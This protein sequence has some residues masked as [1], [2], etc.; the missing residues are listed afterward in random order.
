MKYSI[1][2]PVRDEENSIWKLIYSILEQ[3]YIPNE[4][5]V[6]VNGSK[7]NT[8]EI[9]KDLADKEEKIRLI[10]SDPWKANAINKIIKTTSNKIMIF[11]DW[12]IKIWN[13]N[14]FEVILNELENLNL[15][16]LWTS[17]IQQPSNRKTPY[18][19][20]VPSWQ[21][22]WINLEKLKINELPNN[23]INDDLYLA[24][25]SYPNVWVSSNAFFYSEKPSIKDIFT[26]Q[27]RIIK[28]IKQIID[29]W[30]KDKLLEYINWKYSKTK[31]NFILWV[32]KYIK[33]KENDYIWTQTKSTKT[34]SLYDS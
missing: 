29:M 19:L 27:F 8:Y 31:I 25:L 30:M 9:V 5:I 4:I 18:K 3:S 14:C 1:W 10:E 28:W 33:L 26:T 24:L 32:I 16:M 21:L 11:C 2:I 13:H 34:W 20:R 6:C 17:I 12:D 22:Y 7:D 15:T 23:I